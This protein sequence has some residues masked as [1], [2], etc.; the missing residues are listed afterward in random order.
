MT[1]LRWWWWWRGWVDCLSHSPARVF[2]SN[3]NDVSF[4]VLIGDFP[5]DAGFVG[6]LHRLAR[7]FF[8]DFVADGT[9]AA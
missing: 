9:R 8:W 5:P 6:W 3:S 2:V 1:F 4:A 7:P